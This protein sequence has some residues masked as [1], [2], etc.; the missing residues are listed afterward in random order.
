M[1]RFIK[2]SATALLVSAGLG[3]AGLGLTQDTAQAL[4]TPAPLSPGPV[5]T[6][7]GDWGPAHHWCP[8]Q[9]L[10]ET[11]NR[12]TDPLRWDMTICHTYYFTYPYGNVAK[13]IWDGDNPPPKPPPPYG[14][15]CHPN[16]TNCYID[17]HPHP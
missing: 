13:T 16:F 5:H 1:N 6:D 3:W 9:P 4:P 10:P 17:N 14:L 15:Y 2:G 8:G 11:G 12:V 7:N